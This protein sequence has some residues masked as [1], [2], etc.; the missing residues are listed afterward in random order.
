[1]NNVVPEHILAE[2]YSLREEIIFRL[3]FQE[4]LINYSLVL[5]GL[6]APLITLYYQSGGLI[7]TSTISY[8]LLLGPFL[9]I[10]LQLIYL[11]QYMYF[12]QIAFY[13]KEELGGPTGV[14]GL[15]PFSKW[16]R[17]LNDTLVKDWRAKLVGAAEGLFAPLVGGIYLLAII[18]I[19]WHEL[20]AD[21]LADSLLWS[22]LLQI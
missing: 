22:G 7:T 5:L 8:A 18:F 11:K 13:I 14:D 21:P 20:L 1:M 2:Y 16:E 17:H 15:P 6:L 19:R 3:R 10:F 9:G 12:Q 4:T